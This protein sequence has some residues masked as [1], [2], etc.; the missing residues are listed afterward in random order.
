[1]PTKKKK[2]S[3]FSKFNLKSTKA[4][5]LAIVAAFA[6]VGGGVMVFQSF[7]DTGTVQVGQF[8]VSKNTLKCYSK[9]KV[10]TDKAKENLKVAK[11]EAGGQANPATY[12]S[13]PGGFAKICA[14]ARGRGTLLS[15]QAAGVQVTFTNTT[16]YETKCSD[17][18]HRVKTTEKWGLVNGSAGPMYLSVITMYKYVEGVTP[19]VTPIY[20]CYQNCGK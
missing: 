15:P 18:F 2:Q 5:G 14:T 9:C 13:L 6:I 11:L 17:P 4:R 8:F 19:T 20:T 7:A 10:V 3:I 12:T 16:K 1:M